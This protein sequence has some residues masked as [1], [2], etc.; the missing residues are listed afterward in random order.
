MRPFVEGGQEGVGVFWFGTSG[1]GYKWKATAL[2]SVDQTVEEVKFRALLS[3]VTLARPA[4]T[5]DIGRCG[6]CVATMSY[7]NGL[8]STDRS[9]RF[10]VI[11]LKMCNNVVL[12][13]LMIYL[14]K[15][16]LATRKYLLDSLKALR[17][18]PVLNFAA[19]IYEIKIVHPYPKGSRRPNAQRG[20]WGSGNL[21]LR[22]ES[23]P[24]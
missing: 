2:Y 24:T 20:G 18:M 19:R 10:R 6:E 8:I 12:I 21:E 7:I 17:V 14:S 13:V 22:I 5:T 11:F 16:A 23:L 1:T 15:R 3:T 4:R 9:S